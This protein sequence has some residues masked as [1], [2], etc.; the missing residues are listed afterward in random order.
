MSKNARN[1]LKREADL[2]NSKNVLKDLGGCRIEVKGR[3]WSQ[4]SSSF[5]RLVRHGK[6]MSC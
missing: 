6:H 1:T 3:K 5:F 4:Q 2:M